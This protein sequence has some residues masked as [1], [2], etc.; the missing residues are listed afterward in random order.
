MKHLKGHCLVCGGHLEFPAEAVG[1]SVECPHCGKV[2]GLWL[3][4][5]PEEPTVPRRTIIWTIITV[6]IL[7]SG[8]AGAVV[9]LKRVEKRAAARREVKQASSN[10]SASGEEQT[11]P[12][13]QP[14]PVTPEP[15]VSSEIILQKTPGTSLV[16]A[17]GTLTNNS[18]HQHFGA[19]AR[20]GRTQRDAFVRQVE[21]KEVDAHQ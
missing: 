21:V 13:S 2:T 20:L 14:G 6:L 3:A 7:L 5:P 11:S 17:V 16:Y 8:L 18:D 15:L 10:A 19:V 4:T 9:A 1:T 12:L